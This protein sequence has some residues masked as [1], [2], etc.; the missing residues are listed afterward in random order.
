MAQNRT[1]M[2]ACIEV[3]RVGPKRAAES[4]LGFFIFAAA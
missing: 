1:E 2:Q 3:V 4:G